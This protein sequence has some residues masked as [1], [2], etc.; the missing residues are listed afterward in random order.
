LDRTITCI[1]PTGDRSI[2]FELCK[3][4]ILSQTIKPDQ[5]VVVDDGKTP[6]IPT[7]EMDYIRRSPTINDPQHTLL[8]NLQAGLEVVKGDYIIFIEDDEYYASNYIEEMIKKLSEYEVVGIGCS[9][10]YG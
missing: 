5:W 1:T 7:A 4:W 2:P 6:L 10:Y 9:K 8:L 3:R